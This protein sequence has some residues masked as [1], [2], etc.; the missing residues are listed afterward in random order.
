MEVRIRERYSQMAQVEKLTE[1][2][3][4]GVKGEPS[5]V[6]HNRQENKMKSYGQ[7]AGAGS[8][9]KV[10]SVIVT[11]FFAA[12]T[13]IFPLF[14][15]DYYYNIQ[16]SKA[17]CF[18]ILTVGMAVVTAVWAIS[19]L[20]HAQRRQVRKGRAVSVGP[21]RSAKVSIVAKSC[22]LLFAVWSVISACL[23][24]DVAAAFTGSYGRYLGAVLIL[25]MVVCLL[26]WSCQAGYLP[27]KWGRILPCGGAVAVILIGILHL[28][29]VDLGGFLT[30]VPEVMQGRFLSTIGYINYFSEFASYAAAISMG[31]YLIRGGLPLLLCSGISCIGILIGN[32]SAGLLGLMAV[33]LLAPL[34]LGRREDFGKRYSRLLLCVSISMVLSALIF[35]A[36]ITDYRDELIAWLLQPAV[37]VVCLLA[38]GAAVLRQH[39][40]GQ[41]KVSDGETGRMSARSKASRRGKSKD[42]LFANERM[43]CVNGSSNQAAPKAASVSGRIR[44]TAGKKTNIDTED[45]RVGSDI[46]IPQTGRKKWQKVYGL[47][48]LIVIVIGVLL[49]LLANAGAISAEALQIT[50]SFAN[51]RGFVWRKL[52]EI[53]RDASAF[54]KIFGYGPDMTQ[55][56]MQNFCYDEMQQIAGQT[57]D[58][59]HNS[60]LQYLITTGLPGVILWC[61]GWISLLLHALKKKV[62]AA[63]PWLLAVI[64]LLL[65]SLVVPEQPMV[66]PL[67][68]FCGGMCLG[69]RDEGS[70]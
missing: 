32:S 1:G 2:Y 24:E 61:G 38:A 13:V 46:E 20:R 57:F 34:L 56:V 47:L 17:V 9:K 43:T 49:L 50:D 66:T 62:E 21:D 29:G 8:A 63:A 68:F 28:T 36:A 25:A 70:A 60:I 27:E 55:A 7:P 59:A 53:Y 58:Q 40:F 64:V 42:K 18:F 31:F 51:Y 52:T 45:R 33:I 44:K 41:P 23:S 67:L 3:V 4:P 69:I 16:W 15:T 22:F 11:F 30:N 10:Y 48:L 35:K 54:R 37:C 6:A 26:I 12:M 39:F 65:E 5:P 14:V 19:N